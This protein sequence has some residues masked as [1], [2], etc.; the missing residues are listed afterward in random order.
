MVRCGYL[1]YGNI[2]MPRVNNKPILKITSTISTITKVKRG[3]SVGYDRTYVAN[4]DISV[5]IV[6]I[7]YADGLDRRLSNKGY[8]YINGKKCP[9][10]GNI[11]MDVTMVDV[12]KINA[13]I[14]D[15]VLIL[16]SDG[17]NVIS[18]TDYASLLSTSPYE[19]QL[20]FRYKRM[21][22]IIV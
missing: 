16:G 7:G 20:K 21:N 19:V 22:Y 11:C 12:S 4:E 2:S 1:M 18:V 6:P 8:F 13:N 14:G 5:A 15:S 3:E 17:V 9:I 10:I